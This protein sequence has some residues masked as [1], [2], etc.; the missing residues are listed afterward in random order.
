[1]TII[2]TFEKPRRR[3]VGEPYIRRDFDGTMPRSRLLVDVRY[4]S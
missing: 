4:W 1:M 3:L 2:L